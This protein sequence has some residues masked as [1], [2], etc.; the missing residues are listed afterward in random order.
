MWRCPKCRSKIDD[1]FEVCWSCGTTPDGVEDPSFVTADEADPI[2]DEEVPEATDL[3]DPFADLAGTPVP[4]LVECYT[5]G[6]AV[7]AKFIADRLMEEG[8]PAIAD[9]IDVN[10]VMGGILPQLWGCG[11]K[12]R[13]RQNDLSKAQAWLKGYEEHRRSKREN[14]D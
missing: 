1:S 6:N 7:E 14:L 3:D 5:A 11:P 2:A 4:D 9:K 8:I 10:M 12:I 13:V